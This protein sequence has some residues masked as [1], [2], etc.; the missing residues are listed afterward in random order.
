M[1]F[2]SY[3]Y[4]RKAPE[5]Q[6]GLRRLLVRDLLHRRLGSLMVRSWMFLVAER[7]VCS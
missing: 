4:D 6:H 1:L 5:E 2:R 7:N 3:H